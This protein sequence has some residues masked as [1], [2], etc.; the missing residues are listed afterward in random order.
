[1]MLCTTKS[2]L[3]ILKSYWRLS[4]NTSHSCNIIR[5]NIII[6]Y[7]IQCGQC[8]FNCNIT[9]NTYTLRQTQIS[10]HKHFFLS[11][12]LKKKKKNTFVSVD[13]YFSATRAIFF[14]RVLCTYYI[15]HWRSAIIIC[16]YTLHNT[17]YIYRYV[18]DIA[19]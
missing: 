2:F 15:V 19:G 4:A 11:I 5:F 16:V 9:H 17:I 12:F 18:A 3:F 7:F 6:H 13:L 10:S 14:H 8:D 1:M